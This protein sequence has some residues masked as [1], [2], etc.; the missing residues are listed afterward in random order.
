LHS[1]TDIAK[2]YLEKLEEFLKPR[3]V[4]IAGCVLNKKLLHVEILRK[5]KWIQLQA[6][7]AGIDFSKSVISPITKK[8]NKITSILLISGNKYMICNMGSSNIPN[9]IKEVLEESTFQSAGEN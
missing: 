3:T 7:V 8:Q 4:L 9:N 5:S 2:I 6:K 1:N